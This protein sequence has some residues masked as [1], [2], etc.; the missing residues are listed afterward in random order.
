MS[1]P[2]LY[3]GA[4]NWRQFCR[5]GPHTAEQKGLINSSARCSFAS[6]AKCGLGLQATLLT[7]GQILS[8]STLKWFFGCFLFSPVPSLYC[9]MHGVIPSQMQ[10]FSHFPLLHFMMFYQPI[11]LAHQHLS[12]YPPMY[13]SVSPVYSIIC[14]LAEGAFCN[15][16]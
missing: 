4:S 6:T 8:T 3:W 13:W 1:V 10:I 14:K 16:L 11:S 15:V 9:C 7:C 5:G 12:K 2:F